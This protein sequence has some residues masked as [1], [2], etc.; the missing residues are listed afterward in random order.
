MWHYRPVEYGERCRG[1]LHGARQR[2][3]HAL[4][5]GYR[6]LRRRL[7][8]ICR[9]E[10]DAH[11]SS[12]AAACGAGTGNE[13]LL[14]GQYAFLL[15]GSAAGSFTADGTGKVT[16]GEEDLLGPGGS[17]SI[18]AATSLYAVGPDHRGCLLLTVL[19]NANNTVLST[20]ISFAF[21]LGSLNSGGVATTGHIIQ[22]ERL[23]SG[24]GIPSLDL[25]GGGGGTLRLQD[26][27]A[28]AANQFNGDYAL[29]FTGGD[30]QNSVN[31]SNRVAI[32]GTFTTDGVS[33]VSSA[34]FDIDDVGTVSSN[35]SSAPAG[36]FT[37]C[38]ANGHGVLN[39]A[40]LRAPVISF[41]MVNSSDAFLVANNNNEDAIQGV[42]EAIAI[43]PG[44][45]FSQASLSG[46]SV[47]RA[48]A[49]SAST[50]VVDIATVSAD[51]RSVMTSNDNTNSAGTF[52][53]GSTPFN[54]SVAANGRVTLTGG[55]TPPVLYLYGPNQ[56]FLVGTDPDVTFGIFEPQSA[57][58]FSNASFSGAYIFGT[59]Y[60]SAN[61]VTMESGVLTA[62]GSGNG[63]GT[64][65]QS[66]PSGITENQTFHL[67]Y[68]ISSSGTGTFGAGTTAIPISRNKLVFINNTSPN[69][70]I[71][72]VEK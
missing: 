37:C 40:S 53:S 44:T 12:G 34:T 18:D 24:G 64:L 17:G 58:P 69:P 5:Q 57:G 29:G 27:N 33:A 59:E 16:G 45:N 49:Q 1:N 20:V 56:G 50:A 35:I 52:N 23:I 39:L 7:I 66:G 62:D 31:G 36:T 26:P 15:E 43:P 8:K 21:S 19:T 54:Y 47:L 10:Y 71:T 13:S 38:D 9:S 22:L 61:T 30:L 28:F 48:T 42:G 2:S 4:G 67:T 70:T 3:R 60:P 6:D 68:S 46:T 63:A 32:A 14:K 65:D 11:N 51:G 25:A 41:Y 55:S 72:I